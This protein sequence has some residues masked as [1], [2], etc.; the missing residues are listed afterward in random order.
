MANAKTYNDLNQATEVNDTDKVALAQSDKQELVTATVGQVAQKVANIVSTDQVTEIVTDLGMG[1]QIMA[2]KLQDK[3]LD[4]T[5]S[6]TL[7]TMANKVDSLDVVG[8]KEYIV[9]GRTY[10]NAGY[11]TI[12]VPPYSI[13]IPET[14]FHIGSTIAVNPIISV[15]GI[16]SDGVWG[17]LSSLAVETGLSSAPNS[18]NCRWHTTRNKNI[19]WLTFGNTIIILQ[20]TDEGIVSLKHPVISQ[21]T[22]TTIPFAIKNDGS[23][24]FAYQNGASNAYVYNCADNTLVATGK[25][26]GNMSSTHYD[27]QSWL[28]DDDTKLYTAYIG[29]NGSLTDYSL[30]LDWNTGNI[31]TDT[32]KVQNPS[33]VAYNS[34]WSAV[35]S[36]D[37]LFFASERSGSTSGI[38]TGNIG[39]YSFKTR[40]FIC[41]K[42]VCRYKLVTGTTSFYPQYV[43]KETEQ[44][45][46]IYSAVFGVFKYDISTNTLTTLIDSTATYKDALCTNLA[47]YVSTSG[48]QPAAP[49]TSVIKIGSTLYGTDTNSTGAPGLLGFGFFTSSTTSTNGC[50]FDVTPICTGLIYKRNA[51]EALFELSTWSD[52]DYEAGAYDVDNTKAEVEI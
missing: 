30:T 14:S 24:Y 2:Q 20:I 26:T 46:K 29:S 35:P 42:S 48:I 47:T 27:T 7:T 52:A 1:K 8:A 33:V 15:Y 5:A 50:M 13:R 18:S 41:K 31:A 21:S 25:I 11:N 32:R 36:K 22:T 10:Y 45:Y 44:V 12:S 4:V 34:C 3:G 43:E 17:E 38:E 16:N 9:T 6:D 23:Q 49:G 28:S 19:V 40:S 39:I 51:Q 37:L